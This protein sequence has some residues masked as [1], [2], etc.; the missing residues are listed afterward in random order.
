MLRSSSFN[1]MRPGTPNAPGSSETTGVRRI[2]SWIRLYASSMACFEIFSSGFSSGLGRGRGLALEELKALPVLH[3]HYEA[4]LRVDL[5]HL[6]A[7][8]DPLALPDNIRPIAKTDD[9]DITD[10]SHDLC[11]RSQ[12]LLELRCRGSARCCV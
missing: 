12:H 8:F 6:N 11:L 3:E 9:D 5:D 7:S 10:Q 4:S 1:E 2:R